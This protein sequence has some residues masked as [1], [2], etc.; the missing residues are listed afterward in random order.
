[1]SNMGYCRFENTYNDL[2]DCLDALCDEGG[3][4]G[5]EEGANKYEKPYVRK[6]VELCQEIAESFGDYE[7]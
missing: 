3:I 5:V 4:E 2:Q 7:D 1:M 6:L